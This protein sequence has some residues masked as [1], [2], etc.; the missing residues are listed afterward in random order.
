MLEFFRPELEREV[1][2]KLNDPWTADGSLNESRSKGGGAVAKWL[3]C[4]WRGSRPR[5]GSPHWR[6]VP[7][8]P[9]V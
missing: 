1:Q 5:S 9:T 2:G 3:C 7:K 6:Q 8:E 4:W